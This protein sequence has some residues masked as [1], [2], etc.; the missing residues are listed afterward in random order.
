MLTGDKRET[1]HDIAKTTC[2]I[3][4]HTIKHEFFPDDGEHSSVADMTDAFRRKLSAALAEAKANKT[5]GKQQQRS[6]SVLI[7]NECVR[8]RCVPTLPLERDPFASPAV[9]C[10]CCWVLMLPLVPARRSRVAGRMRSC[11]PAR[12]GGC[13]IRHWGVS[14]G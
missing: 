3:D 13:R 11:R 7:G 1:A 2:L 9:T 10:P 5:G 14:R 8:L 4:H 6:Y 12:R